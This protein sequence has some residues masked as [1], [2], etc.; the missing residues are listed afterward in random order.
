MKYNSREEQRRLPL[1]FA[2]GYLPRQDLSISRRVFRISS[3]VC[4]SFCS[5][6]IKQSKKRSKTYT[7]RTPFLV[8]NAILQQLAE[9]VKRNERDQTRKPARGA[10]LLFVRPE[11]NIDCLSVV[12]W[13]TRRGWAVRFCSPSRPFGGTFFPRKATESKTK[14]RRFCPVEIFFVS[15]KKYNGVALL[16]VGRRQRISKGV[17]FG[18]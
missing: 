6:S 5:C 3:A 9:N 12:K 11:K 16:C 18:Q 8:S 1:P 4:F 2:L 10:L 17:F 13:G 14:I 7:L 15:R